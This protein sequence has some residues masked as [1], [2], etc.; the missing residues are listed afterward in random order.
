MIWSL[1]IANAS[2]WG[3]HKLCMRCCAGSAASVAP[4]RVSYTFGFTGPSVAVDTACSSSL[5]GA[6]MARL[7]MLAD[8]CRTAVA[9]G[10]G[11]C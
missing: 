10:A 2:L 3:M 7:S 1:M 4:G 8:T 5:V 9:S 11:A 6:H